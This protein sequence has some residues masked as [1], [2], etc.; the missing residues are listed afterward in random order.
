MKSI[1][2]VTINNLTVNLYQR[3]SE[4]SLIKRYYGMNLIFL[5]LVLSSLYPILMSQLS[6]LHISTINFFFGLASLICFFPL[7][8][9]NKSFFQFRNIHILR[10]TFQLTILVNVGYLTLYLFALQYSDPIRVSVLAMTQTLFAFFLYT[11]VLRTE[12]FTMSKFTGSILMLFGSVVFVGGFSSLNSLSMGDIFIIMGSMILPFAYQMQ[13]NLANIASSEVIIVL[14]SFFSVIVF[15]VWA[16]FAN[17]I[18]MISIDLHSLLIISFVSVVTFGISSFSW[19]EGLRH[20]V[21]SRAV[22]FIPLQNVF[23]VVFSIIFLGVVISTQQIVGIIP[24]VIGASILLN[25]EGFISTFTRVK[26]LFIIQLP[27]AQTTHVV[28]EEKE[29]NELV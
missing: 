2:S 28:L 18:E 20:V 19:I 3:V 23:T 26:H 1:Q 7:I 14:R 13:K 4:N 11:V 29:E 15:G 21:T 12:V 27:T 8:I 17:P 24:I 10:Q 25:P 9:K 22:S 16:L 6:N 5:S